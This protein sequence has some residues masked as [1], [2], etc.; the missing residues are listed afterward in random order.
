MRRLQKS[1]LHDDQKQEEEPGSAGA[2]EVL[3]FVPKAHGAQ[4][5]QVGKG[6]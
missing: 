4:R 1:E 3:P 6:W 5:G 2:E